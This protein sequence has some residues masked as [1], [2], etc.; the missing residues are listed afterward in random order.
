MSKAID[1]IRIQHLTLERSAPVAMSFVVH[2]LILAGMA[3][4]VFPS[5]TEGEIQTLVG[6]VLPEATVV[7]PTLTQLPSAAPQESV[8]A[9]STSEVSLALTTV[10]HKPLDAT[11]VSAEALPL[12]LSQWGQTAGHLAEVVGS[13]GGQSGN[14]SG[15]D[16]D[17]F[18]GLGAEAKNVVFVIDASGSM[19]FPVPEPYKTRFGRVKMEMLNA[20]SRMTEEE[21]FFMIFFNDLA[22]P[23][24]TNRMVEAT[25]GNQ[26][27][28]L[29]W[30]ASSRASGG[31][32]PE[33]ALL[34]ALRLQPDVIYFLTDGIFSPKAVRSVAAANRGKVVINTICFGEDEGGK[35]LQQI[36]DQNGG[37]Y[38][39]VHDGSEAHQPTA[40]RLYRL[41]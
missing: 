10:T 23:M 12:E 20:I 6:Q 27:A 30:M 7:S 34:M 26:Q 5:G 14:G 13:N 19:N 40:K 21:K 28:Y 37:S 16:G 15:G 36:A 8:D 2:L 32:N 3:L 11:P 33:E 25:P 38:K 31:T 17:G 18:F 35:L 9:A 4:V 41:P 1:S 39:F 29:Q 24:P 22:I